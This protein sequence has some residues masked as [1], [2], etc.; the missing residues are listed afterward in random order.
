MNVSYKWLKDYLAFDLTPEQLAADLTSIG[1]ET[2]AVERV[3]SIRGGLRGLVV[4]KV[5]TCI[6][7]PDR[8]ISSDGSRCTSQRGG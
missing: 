7:H 4:G 8:R 2:G 6:E 3:E 5:L 1:L